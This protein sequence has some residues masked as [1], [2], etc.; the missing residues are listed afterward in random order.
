MDPIVP[1]CLRCSQT[2]R[3]DMP[4]IES[5][6]DEGG[7]KGKGKQQKLPW[8][9][10]EDDEDDDRSLTPRIKKE[11]GPILQTTFHRVILDEVSINSDLASYKH[12][13]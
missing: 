9:R 13:F 8:A 10:Q 11:A 12:D 3:S 7:S 4:V 2:L 6:G 5:E 1:I